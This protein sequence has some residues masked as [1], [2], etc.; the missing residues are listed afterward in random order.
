MFL[1]QS[2]DKADDFIKET[3]RIPDR[4]HFARRLASYTHYHYFGGPISI[5][6]SAQSNASE[7]READ[8]MKAEKIKRQGLTF[9]D[10]LF[11]FHPPK[12]SWKRLEFDTRTFR[13]F[14]RE[15]LPF[16]PEKD[17]RAFN[18]DNVE[19]ISH[20]SRIT[21]KDSGESRL[22]LF[23]EVTNETAHGEA[24]RG[25]FKLP[26][27]IENFI[28]FHDQLVHCEAS[29]HQS[30]PCGSS[31]SSFR[32]SRLLCVGIFGD[33]MALE[34]DS[35]VSDEYATLSYCWG[36]GPFE[37]QTTKSNVR[38]RSV[39]GNFS[40]RELP[41]TIQDAITVARNLGLIHLWVDA[42]C[43]I[44]ND[45][46]D[47]KRELPTMGEI[48]GNSSCTIA[49]TAAESAT[50]GFLGSTRTKHGPKIMIST[51][52]KEGRRVYVAE[53]VEQDAINVFEKDVDE[54]RLNSRGWVMQERVLSRRTIHFGKRHVYFECEAGIR[55]E[56]SSL[57]KCN[58]G[59]PKYFELAFPKSLERY[60]YSHTLAFLE[61][62][63]ERFTGCGL[64]KA[65]DRKYAMAGLLK[66]LSNIKYLGRQ[67]FG[68]FDLYLHRNLLWQRPNGEELVQINYPHSERVPSWSWMAYAGKIKF[69]KFN[70]DEIDEP[71]E[72]SKTS[73][74][75]N[76]S[77]VYGEIYVAPDYSLRFDL[78]DKRALIADVWQFHECHFSPGRQRWCIQDNLHD[79]RKIGWIQYDLEIVDMACM[80][81]ILTVRAVVV[82]RPKKKWMA[83]DC[84]CI[85]VVESC[86]RDSRGRD[87][88][89]RI[90]VGMIQRGHLTAK[91]EEVHIL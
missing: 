80:L 58:P 43:I 21:R 1:L 27:T 13:S 55:F 3:N 5:A 86:G 44:Q 23:V 87:A 67:R 59:G 72:L 33:L 53:R 85:L 50:D 69:G 90:G 28:P 89:R 49:A 79:R 20:R 84:E 68:I 74:E 31:S 88:Y 54:S 8:R 30:Q 22:A 9:N 60:G 73:T 77:T 32:P 18:G 7:W 61:P 71:E 12:N 51:L 38:S 83:V 56:D 76:R 48:Y 47:M 70:S 4:H 65:T 16:F 36:E 66:H 39:M 10:Q 62:F 52:N 26:Q 41:Q 91:T 11:P 75:S 42:I 17:A 64:S 19:V 24:N 40:M 81:D 34:T 2:A 82:A 35:F 37:Y 57:L 25:M 6:A 46:E 78:N 29:G 14:M 63:I 45:E 15:A